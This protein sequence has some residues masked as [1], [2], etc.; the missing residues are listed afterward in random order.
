MQL[1]TQCIALSFPAINFV[2][3]SYTAFVVSYALT[4]ILDWPYP[5]IHILDCFNYQI[6]IKLFHLSQSNTEHCRNLVLC[7]IAASVF[8][9]VVLHCSIQ[10]RKISKIRVFLFTKTCKVSR[11]RLSS[12]PPGV[13]LRDSPHSGMYKK[14]LSCS[15]IM[16]TCFLSS[17]DQILRSYQLLIFLLKV[18][19][20]P[21]SS[22]W[23]NNSP[24]GPF[25][26]CCA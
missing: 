6:S 25:I 19:H 5:Y 9:T 26:S 10:L 4:S 18:I 21:W 3:L 7:L 14:H 24:K 23:R 12:I 2:P 1:W 11:T 16:Q 13:V 15:Q 17:S 20:N 8:T 22:S